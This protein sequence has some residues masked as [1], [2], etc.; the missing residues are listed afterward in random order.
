VV[1][2]PIAPLTTLTKDV[3]PAISAVV[4]KALERNPERR[5]ATCAQF[6]DALERAAEAPG[7]TLAATREVAAYVSSVIGNEIA[8]QREAVRAWLAMSEP[9]QVAIPQTGLPHGMPPASSVS[10]GAM[11]VPS[12]EHSHVTS[13][14][15]NIS[16]TPVPQRRSMPL[17]LGAAGGLLLLVVIAIAIAFGGTQNPTKPTVA[18]T[19]KTPEPAVSEASKANAAATEGSTASSAASGEPA[20]TASEASAAL[21]S[22]QDDRATR[23]EKTF[24]E[25]R[26][27]PPPRP[28]PTKREDID[29]TNPYR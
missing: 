4:M 13:H 20:A 28:P 16:V 11:A 26:E 15:S 1:S 7:D 19:P 8:Q 17:V 29:L 14:P 9:S 27:P 25:R 24:R 10:S 3:T 21:P 18:A 12:I 6:A 22:A 23:R 2:E 5:Y